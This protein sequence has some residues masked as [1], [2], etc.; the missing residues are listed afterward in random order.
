[1]KGDREKISVFTEAKCEWLEDGLGGGGCDLDGFYF[2][3]F[4]K[5]LR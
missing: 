5:S 2:F 4:L 3:L 1:M